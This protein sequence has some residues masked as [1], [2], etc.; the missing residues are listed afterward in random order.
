MRLW[1]A[2]VYATAVLV[3]GL[4]ATNVHADSITTN[5]FYTTSA[6]PPNNVSKAVVTLSQ[7]CVFDCPTR[8]TI[9]SITPLASLDGADGIIFAPDGNLL[10]GGQSVGFGGGTNPAR[11]H[12]ITANGF[13]VGDGILPSGNGAYHLTIGP[14][15]DNTFRLALRL[16]CNS[17][18][19]DCGPHYS[20]FLPL[21]S[22]L[23]GQAADSVNVSGP[24]GADLRLTGLAFDPVNNTWYYGATPQGSNAGDFGTI[25]FGEG[26]GEVKLPFV[27]VCALGGCPAYNLLYDPSS[28]DI[29]MDGGSTVAQFDPLTNTIVSSITV[30]G[31]QFDGAA[32]DGNG[33]LF[34]ASNTGNLL[35]VDYSSDADHLINGPGAGHVV[36]PLAADLSGV[37]LPPTV[38]A[39]PEPTSI[40][41]LGMG[42]LA[43]C[44][45]R[46]RPGPR[47]GSALPQRR[48][49]SGD[50]LRVGDL[51][52]EDADVAGKLVHAGDEFR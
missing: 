40:A 32:V 12:E 49:L 41:L 28:N 13:L 37:A 11:V 27:D 47:R 22:P 35:G 9:G 23:T 20:R 34:V 44:L 19:G 4:T 29:I 39:A 31:E 26:A 7:D 30:P 14:A 5:L 46:C 17:P 24:P 48:E 43:L 45:F 6:G 8:L 10:I 16:L 1:T 51:A 50:D 3:C 52:L 18:T 42:L 38:V 36:A 21:P 2:G 33:H 25:T 15:S